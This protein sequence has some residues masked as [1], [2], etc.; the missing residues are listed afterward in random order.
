M[1]LKRSTSK[2]ARQANI[3]TEI[4]AGRPIKQ[5][6]AI[7]YSVAILSQLAVFPLFGIKV[8]LTDNLLIGAFFTVISLARSYLV[9]R[10]FNRIKA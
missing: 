9:R 8:T 6:V 1:P 2:A 10:L 7:G 3:K 4:A 5:A